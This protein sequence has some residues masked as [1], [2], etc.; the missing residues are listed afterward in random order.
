M[1]KCL[2]AVFPSAYESFMNRTS[3]GL[4]SDHRAADCK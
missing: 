1:K 3:K 4:D 2:H